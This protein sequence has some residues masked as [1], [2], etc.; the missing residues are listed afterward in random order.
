MRVSA[1]DELRRAVIN[2]LLC[3]CVVVK[4]EIELEFG[5]NF[6]DHFAREIRQLAEFE[7]DELVRMSAD[8]IEV[9]GLGRIFI[10]NVAMVFDE[11]A[12]KQQSRQQVFSKTL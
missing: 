3:H 7:R 1:E 2:R 9:A 6:D 11:Y 8:R 5:V 12:R 4:S 10:R